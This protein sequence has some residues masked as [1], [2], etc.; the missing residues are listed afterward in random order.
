ML[1]MNNVFLKIIAVAGLC[2]I[3][4]PNV[5]LAQYKGSIDAT[6]KVEKD[7]AATPVA[8][9]FSSQ[10][11]SVEQAKNIKKFVKASASKTIKYLIPYGT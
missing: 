3:A 10:V 1:I 9:I 7:P 11:T 4:T 5:A 8:K 2:L 6:P